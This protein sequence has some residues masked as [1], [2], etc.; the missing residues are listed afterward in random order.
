M[1]QWNLKYGIGPL[2]AWVLADINYLVNNQYGNDVTQI[3]FT[4]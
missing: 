4:G 2:V 3:I 1:K